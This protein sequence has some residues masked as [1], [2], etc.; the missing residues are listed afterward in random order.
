M[1]S[2]L[3][4]S[5]NHWLKAPQ[6]IAYKLAVLAYK[7]LHGT[8]PSYLAD[9]LLQSADSETRTPLRSASTSSLSVRRTRLSTVG[10]RAFRSTPL[11]P[12]TISHAMS[13]PHHLCQFSVV[14]WRRISSGVPSRDFCSACEVTL[15]LLDTLIVLVT[16]LLR[17]RKAQSPPQSKSQQKMIQDWYPDPESWCLLKYCW[18]TTLSASVISSSFLKLV[19]DY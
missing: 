10:D 14:A 3:N 2:V 7:C 18:F 8:A 5:T 9:E 6:R 17:E 4:K 12:G 19:A 16:Y 13:R 11:V 15:S 1:N